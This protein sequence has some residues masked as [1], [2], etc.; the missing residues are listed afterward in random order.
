MSSPHS[1]RGPGDDSGDDIEASEN[2]DASENTEPSL[3]GMVKSWW[4][5]VEPWRRLM[6][7]GAVILLVASAARARWGDGFPDQAVFAA[8]FGGYILLAL[9]FA[10]FFRDRRKP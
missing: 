9:G 8:N 7:G 6:L 3:V 2:T 1:A 5:R 10:Q 4:D